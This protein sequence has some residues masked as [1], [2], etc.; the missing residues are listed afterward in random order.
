[1]GYV[2]HGA[3][4]NCTF[5]LVGACQN[6]GD[7]DLSVCSTIDQLLTELDW[8]EPEDFNYTQFIQCVPP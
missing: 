4:A 5:A 2:N 3:M 1:M 7:G 6:T 8:S